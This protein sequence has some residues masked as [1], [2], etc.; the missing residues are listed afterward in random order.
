MLW[1]WTLQQETS[2]FSI[3]STANACCANS[4]SGLAKLSLGGHP[5]DEFSYAGVITERGGYPHYLL[6]ERARR[7]SRPPLQHQ[8]TT[9]RM[10]HEPLSLELAQELREQS[11]TALSVLIAFLAFSPSNALQAVTLALLLYTVSLYALT[12]MGYFQGASIFQCICL[13]AIPFIGLFVMATI[14]LVLVVRS[15]GVVI[16]VLTLC[17]L[18]PLVGGLQRTW[19]IQDKSSASHLEGRECTSREANAAA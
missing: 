10:N 13:H 9:S 12:C 14:E 2:G 19:W 8:V 1:A 11:K 15:P 6:V 18:L 17:I 3:A 4:C 16:T 5:G 7:V